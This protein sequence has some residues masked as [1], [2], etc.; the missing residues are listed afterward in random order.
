MTS[1]PIDP[2]GP[3]PADRPPDR[4][5]PAW[6]PRAAGAEPPVP[7]ARYA[8]PEED[9]AID[10]VTALAEFA[11]S[12]GKEPPPGLA[13]QLLD[14]VAPRPADPSLLAPPCLLPLLGAAAEFLAQGGG[15]EDEVVRIGAVALGQELRAHRALA[16][17]RAML[18]DG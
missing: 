9:G 3:P 14:F 8:P 18:I 4:A 13:D 17:R 12:E 1:R 7:A 6:A 10:P 15:Q 11:A 2:A 16:E 5:E